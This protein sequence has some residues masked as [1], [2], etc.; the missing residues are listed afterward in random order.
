MIEQILEGIVMFI[1]VSGFL[2]S[3]YRI[4]RHIQQEQEPSVKD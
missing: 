4:D 3:F 2:Y 1:V